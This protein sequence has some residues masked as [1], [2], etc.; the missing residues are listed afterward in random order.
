MRAG[1]HSRMRIA[2]ISAGRAGRQD[3]YV[4]QLT[5]A[6]TGLGH[7]ATRHTPRASEVADLGRFG[8]R[9]AARWADEGAPDVV[10][11]HSWMDCAVALA[12][13]RLP[14]VMTAH[15][16]DPIPQDAVCGAA[17]HIIVQNGRQADGFGRLGV[18]E[19]RISVIPSGVDTDRFQP[20]HVDIQSGPLHRILA[21]GLTPGDGLFSLIRALPQLPEAELTI[22][23]GPERGRLTTDPLVQRLI[24]LAKDLWVENRLLMLGQVPG[25]RMPALY[26]SADAM[27]TVRT[28]G[29]F[30]SAMQEA[31]ACGVPVVGYSSENAQRTVVSGRTGLLT[32]AGDIFALTQALS[33]A[34][35]DRMTRV[36][37]GNAARRR[38]EEQFS[39]P[40][41][42]GQVTRVYREAVA[43]TQAHK[44]PVNT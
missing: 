20:G 42:A 35:S 31:M 34:L 23:G 27:V 44:S 41:I 15:S 7:Q 9:L 4:A 19:D 17:D 10:H 12:A 21:V 13:T 28:S 37:W 2:M 30:S 22:A 40:R 39:W 8:K 38:A 43:S 33:S 26:R 1:N 6:L 25:D 5:R 11:V 24:G 32:P 14:L 3:Q 29:G 36:H 18:E 16:V